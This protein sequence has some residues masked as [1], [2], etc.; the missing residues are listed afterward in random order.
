[1]R[2]ELVK[3]QIIERKYLKFRVKGT[4]I[5]KRRRGHSNNA[6]TLIITAL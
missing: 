3:E 4:E 1:M 5:E 2:R 6:S